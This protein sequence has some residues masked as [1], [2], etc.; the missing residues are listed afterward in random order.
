[1]GK[2]SKK[3]PPP[4]KPDW[5]KLEEII[6]VIQ[7]DLAPGAVVRHDHKVTGKSG[8]RRQLDVTISQRISTIPVFIVFECKRYARRVGIEKVEAFATKLRD[9]RASCGV[10]VS[11]TG[12]DE[13]AQ[14]MAAQENVI[15]KNYREAEETDWTLLVGTSFWLST[16]KNHIT[17]AKCLAFLDEQQHSR[18]EVP[19]GLALFD[20][21]RQAYG[22]PDNGSFNLGELFWDSWE[23]LERP[24][25]VGTIGIVMDDMQPPC[26]I[27]MG[28]VLTRVFGFAVECKMLAKRYSM[29]LQIREGKILENVEPRYPEYVEITSQSFRLDDVKGNQE[30]V[31]LTPSEWEEVERAERTHEIPDIKDALF[32]LRVVGEVQNTARRNETAG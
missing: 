28:A 18:I 23:K 6:A 4:E 12:F 24:R 25:K 20:Q 15:L 30:G 26:Y 14:A 16:T 10:M 9:V 27:E 32:R 3:K 17:D 13:G 19:L 11:Q 5:Q 2:G 31:L 8:R 21:N 1:M 22:N 7:T 29:N